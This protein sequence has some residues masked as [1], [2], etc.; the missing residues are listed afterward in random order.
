MRDYGIVTPKFWIGETGRALRGDL[1]AQ[2]VAAYLITNPH[3]N[4][5]GLYYLPFLY[6][7]HETGIDQ[8][9]A[10]RALAKLESEGFAHYDQASEHVWVVEMARFQIGPH[11]NRG[12]KR[13]IGIVR[14]L[15][16]LA[17]NPF[18]VDFRAKYGEVYHL[19]GAGKGPE[20][21]RGSEGPSKDLPDHSE[22]ASKGLSGEEKR[23]EQPSPSEGATK[24]LPRGFEAQEGSEEA[25]SKPG[26]GSGSGT[27]SRTGAGAASPLPRGGTPR[28]K[29]A[30][31]SAAAIPALQ[32][33]E[34]WNEACLPPIKPVQRLSR[35]LAARI[36]SLLDDPAFLS[37]WPEICRR[38]NAS[39]FCRGKKGFVATLGWAIKPET[40][41]RVLAGEYD[42]PDQEDQDP[43]RERT[44][45]EL[46][47]ILRQRIANLEQIAQSIG[48][49]PPDLVQARESL[50]LLEG[51]GAA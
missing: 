37:E 13:I 9:S 10:S 16:A 19:P 18:I 46:A 2:V 35:A 47:A 38:I 17:G 24:G 43:Q 34:A 12:D 8:D 6:L 4:M 29:P 20:Q 27:G 25:P 39:P 45:A 28:G 51:K 32:V 15:E 40:W 41:D 14:E 33:L 49:D 31:A 1:A 42:D 23:E 30:A 26:S 5:L 36:E 21:P 22:G 44:T 50:A 3:A 7:C 48:Y 11:L